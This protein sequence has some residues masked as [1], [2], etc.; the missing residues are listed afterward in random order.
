[1]NVMRKNKILLSPH[2]FKVFSFSVIAAV[3]LAV[4]FVMTT[5]LNRKLLAYSESEYEK[6]CLNMLEGYAIAVEQNMN[7]YKAALDSFYHPGIYLMEGDRHIADY[8]RINQN[9]NNVFFENIYYINSEGKAYF[10][11]GQTYDL[12]GREY[13]KRIL[14]GESKFIITDPLVSLVSGRTMLILARAVYD[15][16]NKVKGVLCGS[17]QLV[18]L[19]DIFSKIQ[20]GNV[21][22][23][24]ILDKNGRFIFHPDKNWLFKIFIPMSSEYYDRSSDQISKSKEGSIFTEN[25]VG[26]PIKLY[27]RGIDELDWIITLSIPTSVSEALRSRYRRY[28]LL[29]MMAEIFVIFILLFIEIAVSDYL[30]KNKK[31]TTMFDSLTTVW[32]REYFEREAAR[33]LARNKKSKFMLIEADIRGFKYININSG[34]DYADTV[35]INF[36]R[37]LSKLVSQ[38]KGMICRGYAD[39]FYLLFKVES[40]HKA[41]RSFKE[42]AG[43]FNEKLK[44]G[45]YQYTPKYGIAFY[46][47]LTR[48]DEN[49]SI[50]KL[51]E[52]ASFAKS[53]IKDSAL[54][55]YAIYD[56]KLNKKSQE[57]NLIETQM[58]KA[59]ENNEFFV[60]YQPKI[61]LATDKIVGAEALV[62]WKNPEL[63]LMAPYKFIPLFEK[64]GFIIKLDY[65]VYD[66][67]FRFIRKC[68]DAELPVVPISVNMSRKHNK[69]EKFVHDFMQILNK[70]QVPTKYVEVELLERSVMDKNTLREITL[71]LH[72]E[73][74]TVAM[75]DF[76]SGESSLNMLTNIPVDVLK[77]DRSF[78]LT[79]NMENGKI[80]E[81]SANFIETLVDLGKNLKKHTVFEGVETEEQRDFLRSI[82]CD[83][84]QGYFYS[85]P[86]TEDEY[87]KFLMEHI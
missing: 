51:I 38:N 52:Q 81:T 43:V 32:S 19:Q 59:L 30:Q 55:Q 16:D 65:Y 1:M 41:M 77:F 39:R 63:G 22:T 50:K 84:V 49:M 23:I 4:I 85:K 11:N 74:F 69:P 68:M 21:G 71:M 53:I 44:S 73:G 20:I 72:R 60:M 45:K 40:I 2:K 27:F 76:G 67:V 31:I 28:Q 24:T 18:Y 25:V 58:A 47:P 5:V 35:I 3:L 75:D 26:T 66:M 87:L 70:H 64:N 29:L 83:A 6:N 12:S 57:D 14:H 8:I 42:S 86:L 46:L 48:K 17:I 79:S 10:K 33:F 80:N 9:T 37:W 36:S 34:S 15:K 61:N 54:V 62:R 82:N 13:F 78:L 56:T 7:T